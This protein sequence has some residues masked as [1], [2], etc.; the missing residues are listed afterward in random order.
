MP[1]GQREPARQGELRSGTCR[2]RPW[3]PGRDARL[4]GIRSKTLLTVMT[5][6]KILVV[7]DE[8]DM[9]FY[10]TAF[11]ESNGYEA[12]AT[13]DGK[14]GLRKAREDRPDLIILDIMM[15]GDGGVK[16]YSRLK[17]D[18][19]L[20][21][22]PVIM[23][24]AVAERSFRHFLAMLNTQSAQPVPDPVAYL[25]KPLDHARLLDSIRQTIG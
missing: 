1:G 12:L 20:A 8:M 21:G 16:M 3:R 23:L 2:G 5:K 7:D 25:E 24:S 6:K 19:A 15:P 13:R 18:P 14:N 4:P 11:L 22:I 9:R 17:S 10:V